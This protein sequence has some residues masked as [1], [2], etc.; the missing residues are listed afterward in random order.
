MRRKAAYVC[1][2]VDQNPSRDAADSAADNA[3]NREGA[4]SA[5]CMKLKQ[6]ATLLGRG[7][8]EPLLFC[9]FT[10]C[11]TE[12]FTGLHEERTRRRLI[13]ENLVYR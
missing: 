6:D 11:C 4:D 7:L 8:V 3:H 12:P 10:W 1:L 9:D 13:Y 2:K 5:R